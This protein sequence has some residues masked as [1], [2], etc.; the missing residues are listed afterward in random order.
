MLKHRRRTIASLIFLLVL[1]LGACA[2]SG[3]AA[4][5]DAPSRLGIGQY[6][7]LT[8][9]INGPHFHQAKKLT[10]WWSA[11]AGVVSYNVYRGSRTLGE[12]PTPIASNLTATTYT[13]TRLGD[14][15]TYYYQ[16]TACNSEGESSRSME[17]SEMTKAPPQI[18]NE[19][20]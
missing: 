9:G 13:D 16:V 1:T 8:L 12:A 7:P 5:P 4:P 19:A 17:A 2:K 10:L 3:H 6:N 18:H 11:S 15:A 20:A 14:G